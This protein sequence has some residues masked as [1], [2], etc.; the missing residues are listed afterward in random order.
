MAK[1]V[2]NYI[3]NQVWEISR[4]AIIKKALRSVGLSLGNPLFKVGSYFLEKFLDKYIKPEYNKMLAAQNK[5]YRRK[6]EE[7]KLKKLD[8]AVN[9]MDK[10][11]TIDIIDTLH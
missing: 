8:E 11:V 6:L 4:D 10:D 3:L 9:E 1:K 5:V 7:I 2:S